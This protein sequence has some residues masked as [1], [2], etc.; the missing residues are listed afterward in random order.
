M[1]HPFDEVAIA[2]AGGV[3]SRRTALRWLSG[4]LSGTF[5]A[6][7]LGE[8]KA[9]ADDDNNGDDAVKQRC[10]DFCKDI[11]PHQRD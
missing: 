5:F 7:A 3:S 10:H 2:M 9:F 8:R 1:E 6:G 11:L 4:V